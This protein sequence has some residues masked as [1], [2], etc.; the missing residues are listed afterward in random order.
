MQS[1][2]HEF[3]TLLGESLDA[4]VRREQTTFDAM[5]AGRENAIVL[6]GAGNLGRKIL[7]GLRN[8]GIE[9]LAFSDANAAN[10]GKSVDGVPVL[11]PN[12]AARQYGK[13]AVF[14][15]AVWSPGEDRRYANITRD[16]TRMGCEV[17]A[18]FLPLLWKYPNDM[19][20]HFRLDLP[21]KILEESRRVTEAFSL[22]GDAVSRAEFVAQIKWMTSWMDPADM[23]PVASEKTYLPLNNIAF[24]PEESFI[25]C[26]A[27]DGDTIRTF[28]AVDV[29]TNG[30]VAAF[31]PDP[32]NWDALMRYTDALPKHLRER[33]ESFPYALG[34]QRETLRFDAQGTVGSTIS[35]TGSIEV[36]CIPLDEMFASRP[37]SYIKM[38]IEGAECDAIAGAA[39]TIRKWRPVLAICIYH[40][41]DHLWRI[42]LQI[43]DL[44]PDYRFILRR[45]EDEFGDVVCYAA[46]P[47]RFKQTDL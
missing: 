38:D 19:L 13:T 30:Y 21:H 25:D 15:V 24:S 34:R 8:N 29:A 42:P 46:P 10:W 28:F 4:C 6:H 9:P 26:G 5:A 36:Q 39:E 20:P 17:I 32:A 41:Q 45:Y 11:A 33:I 2:E 7:R 37:A 44:C 18:P 47:E 35:D 14:V 16:L 23:P 12:D 31:E 1:I 3:E 43:R 22:F 27:Y 40:R